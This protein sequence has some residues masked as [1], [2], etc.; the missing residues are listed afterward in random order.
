MLTK[1][2]IKV[3]LVCAQS[4]LASALISLWSERK[5]NEDGQIRSAH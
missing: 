2:E 5:L 1:R 4:S 3:Y